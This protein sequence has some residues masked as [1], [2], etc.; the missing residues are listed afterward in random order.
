MYRRRRRSLVSTGEEPDQGAGARRP[1]FER[2]SRVLRRDD[3][4]TPLQ[5][6][7]VLFD[8]RGGGFD[9][10]RSCNSVIIIVAI[11]LSRMLRICH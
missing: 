4:A 2:T 8:A 9:R 5:R 10:T 6:G 7:K 11:Q 3:D 1:G